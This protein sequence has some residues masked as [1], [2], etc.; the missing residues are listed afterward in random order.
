MGMH[1]RWNTYTNNFNNIS[2]N[3]ILNNVTITHESMEKYNKVPTVADIVNT[4]IC[5]KAIFSLY[6]GFEVIHTQQLILV[7]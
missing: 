2:I 3:I 6:I 1:M 5:L 7:E 4:S